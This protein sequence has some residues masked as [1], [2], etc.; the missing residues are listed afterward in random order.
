MVHRGSLALL[1][2]LLVAAPVALAADPLVGEDI[3]APRVGCL[4]SVGCDTQTRCE[5]ALCGTV[6]TCEV[7]ARNDSTCAINDT[8]SG[9]TCD[10]EQGVDAGG[11]PTSA[12]PLG[13]TTG[14]SGVSAQASQS[15]GNVSA[16]NLPNTWSADTVSAR[17]SVLG[18]DAPGIDAT[19]YK[20]TIASGGHEFS[21]LD[22]LVLVAGAPI[23]A[24]VRLM[25]N[26]PEGCAASSDLVAHASFDCRRDLPALP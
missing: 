1:F 25:D 20:S 7:G 16:F 19:L 18:V 13:L 3:C 23:G 22:V 4:S 26:A 8:I 24:T 21:T 11:I 6:A 5:A 2:A 15:E 10:T 9:H 17:A 14:A 12:Q